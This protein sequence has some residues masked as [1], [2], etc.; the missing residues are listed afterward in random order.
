MTT[1][2][3]IC[4]P[5]EI[6]LIAFL[7][8]N[9]DLIGVEVNPDIGQ[10]SSLTLIFALFAIIV[11]FSTGVIFAKVSM[12]SKDVNV[13]WKGRFLLIA[14]LF[15]TIAAALDS[16]S[17]EELL[18]ISIIRSLLI[19]SSIFYYFGFFLPKQIANRLITE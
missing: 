15:F 1:F 18:I 2:L 5:Y 8:V 19:L 3:I 11:A 7:F 12:N 9:P 17:W 6:L 16:F 14:F 10:R 13:R 4:E